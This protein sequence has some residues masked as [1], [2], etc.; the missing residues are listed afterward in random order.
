MLTITPFLWFETQAEEAM[1][2][3]ASI[4]PR[5]KVIAVNR[6]GD[7]VM[8]VVYELEGQK[9]MFNVARSARRERNG[10]WTLRQRRRAFRSSIETVACSVESVR[11]WSSSSRCQSGTGS[12]LTDVVRLSQMSSTSRNRSAAGRSKISERSAGRLMADRMRPLVTVYGG[13]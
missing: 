8:S 7:T 9:F 13:V 4:F 2:Y 6:A 11:R 10:P 12:S 1:N 5:A 3:Y